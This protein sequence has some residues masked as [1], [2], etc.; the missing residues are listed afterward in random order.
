MTRR[1]S[2]SI[3]VL[4]GLVFIVLTFASNLFTVGPAF[5]KMTDGFRPVMQTQDLQAL[6]RDVTGLAAAGTEFGTKVV[7][8]L[9]DRL[10]TTPEEFST[11][12]GQQFPDSATGVAAI[13]QITVQ[14]NGVTGLL[15]AE[16]GRF[17]RADAIP[18]SSLPATT[19]PWSLLF[20]GIV[21]VGVGL[22]MFTF[23]NAVMAA[24]VLGSIV[25]V[26]PLA[27]SLPSKAQAADTMNDHLRPVYTAEL[28]A[29][30]RQSLGIVQ[31][32]ATDMQT[33]VFP[34]LE[35]QLR[36]DSVQLQA[37]LGGNFPALAGALGNLPA[38]SARFQSTVGTF[39][40]QLANY[41][42]IKST[43]LVPIV[44]T[45]IAGGV[46]TMLASGWAIGRRREIAPAL[47]RRET[48]AA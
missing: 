37:F 27:M 48:R 46:V 35:Q 12:L 28:V 1:I 11:L 22:A 42:K 8:A 19:V 2:A 34:F 39:D 38:S 14:F 36:I 43:Q 24:L 15:T 23:R 16:Q 13:P 5:E 40:T 4:V 44:W 3:V 6:Q 33:R 20:V 25:V 47:P 41:D 29:G 9:A 45:A 7:P 26:V 32:M 18:T 21:T 10:N 31:A 30:A 17:E